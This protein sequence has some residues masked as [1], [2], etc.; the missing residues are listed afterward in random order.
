MAIEYSLNE[1]QRVNRHQRN[2]TD[3]YNHKAKTNEPESAVLTLSGQ[4]FFLEKIV[5]A[6][7]LR[8]FFGNFRFC[9][10]FLNQEQKRVRGFALTKCLID[11]CR[12]GY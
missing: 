2:T 5:L 11:D 7:S 10:D 1:R 8:G 3:R 12:F 4:N 9:A 6:S